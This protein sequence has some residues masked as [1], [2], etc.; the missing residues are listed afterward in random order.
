[1]ATDAAES[2]VGTGGCAS[3]PSEGE[4]QSL[5]LCPI[6]GVNLTGVMSYEPERA[7]PLFHAS[8]IQVPPMLESVVKEFTKAAI[9]EQV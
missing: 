5:A 1:M 3:E 7:G 8:Q 9:R 6:R 4:R 2:S